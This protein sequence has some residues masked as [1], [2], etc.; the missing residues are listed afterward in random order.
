M[1][2][3]QLLDRALDDGE[4]LTKDELNEIEGAIVRK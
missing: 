3:T 2:S 4:S 1:P